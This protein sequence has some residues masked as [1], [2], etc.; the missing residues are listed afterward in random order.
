MRFKFQ[1]TVAVLLLAFAAPLCRADEGMWL[2]NAFPK[3]TVEK[4]YHYQVTDAFLDHMRLSAVR[5][6]NGG[7]GSFVSPDGLLFTNH[8][9]GADCIQKISTGK[10]D[11]MKNGFVARTQAEEQSCPDLEI[12][13]LLKIEDVTARVTEGITPHTPPAEANAK[14]KAAMSAIEKACSDST[15]NRC[16]IVTLYSG[17]LYNLYQYRKYTDIRL[18]MAPE[19]GI[20][21][22]GGDEENFTYPRYNL[23]IT[24]FRAYENGK[25]A[26][27]DNYFKWSKTGVKEGD[28]TFVP[29]NPGST[30]RLMT[31]TELEFSGKYSYPLVQRRLASLISALEAYMAKGP[32]QKRIASENLFGNQNS[33]KAYSGFLT[34][35]RDK[36]LMDRKRKEENELKAAIAK[37]PARAEEFAKFWDELAT[38]Y[39]N[40]S[41]FYAPYW[42]L[43]RGATRG[44]EMLAIARDIVRY[45][46]EKSKP[47]SQRLREYTA[48]A[49]PSLEQEMYSTAPIYPAMEQVVLENYFSFLVKELGADNAVVKAILE[50]RT[51][52]EA[53]KFY[54]QSS[55]LPLVAERKR[56]AASLAEVKNSRDGMIRLALILDKPA[57]E[58]RK[59]YEDQVES[60][61]NRAAGRIALARFAA[62]GGSEYPDATF[63][64]RIAYGDV[65]GYTDEAGHP[66][67]YATDFA[68]LYAKSSD[69]DPF[70]IPAAWMKAKSS[71]NLKTHFN[72]VTTADTHGGNS[73][74]ATL[75][76]KGEIVGILFD[77]NIESLP[78]RFVYTDER[79]RSVHVCSEAIAEAL[80]KVYKAERLLRE[81][82]IESGKPT[83]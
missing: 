64:L 81:L 33:Y 26:H 82:G 3:Q 12:N 51:P 28:L 42:L 30:G 47:D 41:A 34:G 56:L 19:F 45:A 18:V 14:K 39:R 17:G 66:I 52:A 27:V 49:L 2:P 32:E 36:R 16:D 58:L 9:V 80:A 79:S 73:G 57:R 62:F 59:R 6:N 8:H 76:T 77:G 37:D 53:A 43:E 10:S 21:F 67:P 74:S 23:D 31:V 22:Y 72:F 1:V 50:G 70:V 46:E 83:P 61:V 20:A 78:N 11:Y 7:T 65:R 15:G 55:K 60:V 63:T 35:L 38:T 54:V 5:F 4:K 48:S 25:P 13:V 24:F 40:Y 44:S 68:G 29:G 75:N 71:L 69:K